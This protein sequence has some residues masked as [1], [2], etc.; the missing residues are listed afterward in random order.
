M[1]QISEH[2]RLQE[3][4]LQ[5][6]QKLIDLVRRVYTP[7]YKH[8]WKEENCEWYFNKFYGVDNLQKELNDADSEYYFVIYKSQNVGILKIHF[9]KPLEGHTKESNVYLHRIFLGYEAQG[10]GVGKAL[11]SWVEKRAK[12]KGKS[13]IWLKAMDSQEQALRFYNKL[14]YQNI[15]K[16]SLDFELIKKDYSGMV[17][18]WKSL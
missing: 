10:Q 5:D 13:S 12:E 3:I 6:Q 17:I 16:T 1:I 14:G 15:G 9:N 7:I 4:L 11:F 2:I 18:F 8:L